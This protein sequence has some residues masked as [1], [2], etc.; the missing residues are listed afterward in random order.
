M[1]T[2]KLIKKL[3]SYPLFTLND[4]SKLVHKNPAYLKVLVQR[5]KG[6]NL[7]HKVERGKYTL[8][9]DPLIFATN[10][11]SPSYLSLWTALRFH[12]LTEQLP[13][14]IFLCT[15]KYKRKIEFLETKIIFLKTKDVWGYKKERYGDFEIFVAEPEK[16]VIDSLLIRKVPLSEVIKAVKGVNVK[17]LKKYAIKTGNKALIKRLGFILENFGIKCDDLKKFIDYNYVLL[18]PDFET[19]GKK[20]KEWKVVVNRSIEND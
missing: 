19:H 4:L 13:R 3:E 14:D 1:E 10:I 17:K 8:H 12:N 18:D 5:L 7:I 6:R 15:S 16:A 11:V 9:K 2:I 20:N